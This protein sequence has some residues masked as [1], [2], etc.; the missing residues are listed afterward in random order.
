MATSI[1]TF[2]QIPAA[3][4]LWRGVEDVL[5]SSPEEIMRELA[6]FHRDSYAWQDSAFCG[7]CEWRHICGGLDVGSRERELSRRTLEAGCGYRKLF[8]ELFM[9]AKLEVVVPPSQ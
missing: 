6:T 5:S 7:K 3:A 2:R 4:R 8:L 9:R 1:Y